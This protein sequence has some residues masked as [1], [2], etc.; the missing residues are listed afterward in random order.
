MTKRILV[1]GSAGFVGGRLAAHLRTQGHEV[2]TTVRRGRS[3]GLTYEVDLAGPGAVHA[4][5]RLRFDAVIHAAARVGSRVIDGPLHRTNVDAT[6]HTVEWAR[7]T[8]CAHFLHISSVAVY[9]L[10]TLGEDRTERGTERCRGLGI[11]Y[12]RSKAAAERI[13]ERSGI[14]HTI[15]RLPAVIGPGDTVATP[16]IAN[17]LC[18]DGVPFIGRDARTSTLTVANLTAVVDRLLALGPTRRAFNCT[19]HTISWSDLV[20]AYASYLGVPPRWRRVPYRALLTH[21][22]DTSFQYL[23]STGWRGAHYPGDEL[24]ARLGGLPDG[25][26]REGV[27][28]AIAAWNSNRR[29]Q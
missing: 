18:G 19:D 7:I 13:V 5:P 28:S 26:W 22:G 8:S 21:L 17:A 9:G 4:L 11:A 6:R 14:A 1:T 3:N 29:A 2:H 24:W 15:L 10:R 25:C 27:R 20:D 12:M 16:A 23:V